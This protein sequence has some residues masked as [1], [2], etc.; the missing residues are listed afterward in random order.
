LL[1]FQTKREMSYAPPE[2]IKVV[3]ERQP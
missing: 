3:I 2:D 1:R